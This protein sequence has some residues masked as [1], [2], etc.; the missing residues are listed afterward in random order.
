MITYVIR[1]L[2]FVDVTYKTKKGKVTH[3]HYDIDN[4]PETVKEFM[5]T[6]KRVNSYGTRATYSNKTL[7]HLR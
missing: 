2:T 1:Y 6:A 4:I 3:R 7:E 5:R